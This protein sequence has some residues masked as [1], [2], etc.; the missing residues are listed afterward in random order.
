MK[1]KLRKNIIKTR[2]KIIQIRKD[3]E[4]PKSKNRTIWKD[5]PWQHPEGKRCPSSVGC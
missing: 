3:R 4:S 5:V 1:R 2:K